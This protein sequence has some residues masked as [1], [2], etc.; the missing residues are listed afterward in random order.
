[1]HAPGVQ[2]V[3]CTCA[4]V[5]AR[6]RRSVFSVAL[7][8]SHVSAARGCPGMECPACTM[9]TCPPSMAPRCGLAL[10][11]RLAWWMPNR[12]PAVPDVDCG[13]FSAELREQPLESLLGQ[14]GWADPLGHVTTSTAAAVPR[15]IEWLLMKA[16]A[17]QTAAGFRPRSPSVA[18]TFGR[19]QVWAIMAHGAG[20]SDCLS[21][22]S[23]RRFVVQRAS[24]VVSAV[25]WASLPFALSSRPACVAA[26]PTA[27]APVACSQWSVNF[28]VRRRIRQ[29]KSTDIGEVSQIKGWP[30]RSTLSSCA[31]GR[32]RILRCSG[33]GT[34]MIGATN[35]NPRKCSKVSGRADKQAKHWSRANGHLRKSSLN[36]RLR[37]G[38]T[39]SPNIGQK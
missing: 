27:R 31:A 35:G 34:A 25:D 24:Q 29:P 5:V 11:P 15:R 38:R 18:D 32:P 3:A 28:A 39:N 19:R 7:L 13:H 36:K 33:V 4:M 6:M 30:M 14:W 26:D 20:H 17:R 1:M 37:G 22:Q 10:R 23:R 8:R 9:F 21:W 12:T 2:P 16:A